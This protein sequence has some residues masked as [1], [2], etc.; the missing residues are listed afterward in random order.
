MQYNENKFENVGKFNKIDL[1]RNGK[2]INRYVKNY[3]IGDFLD[4]AFKKHILSKLTENTEQ[5]IM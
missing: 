2:N 1:W 5:V 3:E 4:L